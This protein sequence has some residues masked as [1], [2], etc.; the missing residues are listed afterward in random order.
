MPS[1]PFLFQNV[2]THTSEHGALQA[3]LQLQNVNIMVDAQGWHQKLTFLFPSGETDLTCPISSELYS[4]KES[5][6]HIVGPPWQV[7]KWWLLLC[8]FDALTKDKRKLAILGV[9]SWLCVNG[10][11]SLSVALKTI[12]LTTSW[13]TFFLIDT[14]QIPAVGR[15]GDQCKEMKITPSSPA[16]ALSRVLTRDSVFS[17]QS[18]CLWSSIRVPEDP[19]ALLVPALGNHYSS[20]PGCYP[21]IPISLSSEE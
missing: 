5:S 17:F 2:Y 1:K 13:V 3:T 9:F 19:H 12:E 14:P 20:S 16:K 7:S 10:T 15:E 4:G 18:R 21:R 8:V 11:F 6:S